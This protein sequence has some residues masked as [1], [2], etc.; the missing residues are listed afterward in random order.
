[1]SDSP[2]PPPDAAAD[3]NLSP[4]D[5]P[6]RPQRPFE[7]DNA[8]KSDDALNRSEPPALNDALNRS[9]PPERHDALNHTLPPDVDDALN[10][11]LPAELDDA[12]DHAL[13]DGEEALLRALPALMR[14]HPEQAH[15]LAELGAA[16]SVIAAVD[17][18]NPLPGWDEAAATEQAMD[19]LHRVQSR[20]AQ[21]AAPAPALAGIV[22]EL[23]D[24]GM[25]VDTLVAQTGL[26]TVLVRLLDR[27]LIRF[28][29]IPRAVIA[30][31]A[32]ALHRDT[33]AL[34]GYLQG[35]PAL[36][37]GASFRAQQA[38]TLG[39]QQDFADAVAAD[40][41]LSDERRAYLLALAARHDG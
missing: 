26:S 33:A 13:E 16:Y 9:E 35:P 12:L 6:R 2:H 29:T 5:Q 19:A 8:L 18:A 34:V 10:R 17:D 37:Q 1:M 20:L 40:P 31:L 30:A 4:H 3:T 41:E 28:A 25:G 14:A 7:S 11:A 27:R 32:Q 24:Q 38:P 36:P 21:R 39:A 15:R 22:R 23:R